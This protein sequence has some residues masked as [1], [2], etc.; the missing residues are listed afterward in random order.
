MIRPARLS[1]VP[2]IARIHVDSWNSVLPPGPSLEQRLALWN[3]VLGGGPRRNHAWV[4]LDGSAQII[5]FASGGPARVLAARFDGELNA[6][7]VAP[8]AQKQG[9]GRSLVHEVFVRFRERGFQSVMAWVPEAGPGRAFCESLGG[10]LL[11]D[12]RAAE[13]A[14]SWVLHKS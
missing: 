13:I 10:E 4:A 12:R 14:L 2:E 6:V 11:P 5:G 3:H 7:Y 9:V 1:D 8:G